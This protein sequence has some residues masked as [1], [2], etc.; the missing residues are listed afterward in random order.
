[1]AERSRP[2][3]D[4]VTGDAGPYSF[5]QWTDV[6]KTLLS[7]VIG[8]AGVF[9][10]Q[11]NALD[12]SGLPATPVDIASGR[13]LVNG[14]WYESDASEAIA[15]PTPAANPRV[16]RIVLRADWALQT[17]R[18]TRIAGAEA[19]APV[20]PA[21]VQVD[22]VT[23]DL[24][25]W[26]VHTTVAAVITVFRDER[27]FIGQYV[28]IGVTDQRVYIESDFFLPTTTMG[29]A[30]R[31]DNWGVEVVGTSVLNAL[32][33]AGFGA[34]AA[35]FRYVG[36]GPGGTVNIRNRNHRPYDINAHLI[37]RAKSPNTDANLDRIMGFQDSAISLTPTNGVFWRADGAGNWFAVTRSAGVEAGSAIDTT[38]ALDDVW[39]KFEIRQV[40]TDVVTFLIDDVVVVTNRI[41]IPAASLFLRAGI[42]DDGG[43][44]AVNDYLDVDRLTLRGDR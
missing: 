4:I 21:I 13:A 36:G 25:L 30:D 27:S 18:L 9:Q 28:P 23:W 33:L 10:D 20:P 2:W 39:R 15:I 41:N 22:G 42:F 12:L 14:I 8:T 17:V 34:G 29:D 40:S 11:L 3:D 5:E 38:Q 32:D 31:F 24:P 7:P 26:Q 35:T 6:W 19:A 43:A 16:D 44:P 37:I 1:M